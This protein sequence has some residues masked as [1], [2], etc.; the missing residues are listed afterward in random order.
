MN[1]IE[2]E[3]HLVPT[4]RYST[5][6]EYRDKLLVGDILTKLSRSF[7]SNADQSNM[8]GALVVPPSLEENP[9][10]DAVKGI[11]EQSSPYRRASIVPADMLDDA[12]IFLPPLEYGGISRVNATAG[13]LEQLYVVTIPRGSQA[14]Y[15]WCWG[16]LLASDVLGTDEQHQNG[17]PLPPVLIVCPFEFLGTVARDERGWYGLKR[18]GGF[19]VL[20][21]FSEYYS[22]QS[23]AA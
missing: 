4:G 18:S 12:S 22:L 3:Q 23:L 2:F 21:Q 10:V 15:D 5:T 17:H 7:Q 8:F 16:K 14:Y 6:V 19:N 13:T 11:W 20:P 1:P 9:V